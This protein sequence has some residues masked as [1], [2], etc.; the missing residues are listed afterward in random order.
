RMPV[1]LPRG[2]DAREGHRQN[3]CATAKRA[4]PQPFGVACA[5]EGHRQ[6]PSHPSHP[7]GQVRRDKCLCYCMS[8]RKI[9]LLHEMKFSNIPVY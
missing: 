3:A 7:T 2:R 5:R 6:D 1:L 4:G 8:N 9:L